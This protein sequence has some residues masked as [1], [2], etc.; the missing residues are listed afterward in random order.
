MELV[1]VSSFGPGFKRDLIDE[2]GVEHAFASYVGTKRLPKLNSARAAF[3]ERSVVQE[4]VWIR[5]NDF[6]RELR[7]LDRIDRDGANTAFFD[8]REDLL[9]TGQIH[10]FVQ[11]IFDS[12]AHERMIGNARRTGEIFGAG[13]LIGED[14]CKQVVGAHPLDRSRHA[15]AAGKAQDGEGSSGVPAP[16]GAEHRS[17]EQSLA[18][19]VFYR[20]RFQES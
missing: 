6:V 12:F 2:G 18:Q 13:D 16:A 1:G 17:V 20:R 14:G 9:E 11:A 10:S 5:V 15:P 3:F 8:G 7:R 4:G 19:N